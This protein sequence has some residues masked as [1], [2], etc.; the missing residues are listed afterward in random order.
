MRYISFCSGVE[1]ATLAWHGL[2]WRPVAFSEIEPFPCAVLA[3]RWP[4][5]PNLG[6]M[7]KLEVK[8]NG[9]IAS[10]VSGISTSEPIDLIVGGTPC[11]V[12]GT[13][14]LT[15]HGY[16]PIE[17][18]R[19]GDMVLTDKFRLRRVVRTGS[20]EADVVTVKIFGKPEIICTPNHPFLVA[21][22]H[23]SQNNDFLG[24]AH[25]KN[26]DDMKY[27]PIGE[28]KG[29][30]A[31]V[32]ER[33]DVFISKILSVGNVLET[34]TVFNIEVE[35]DHT[36]VAAG[37]FVH[38]CQSY[39]VA[40]KREGNRG[41]SGLSLHYTTMAYK[42]L[43]RWVLWENV[44]GC[45]SSTQGL[46]F[47]AFLSG[48]CGWDAPVPDGGW[49]NSGICTN[50]PGCF[51][52]AWRTLDCQ[53]TRVPGFP[54]AIPQRRR[55][56]F[57]VGYRGQPDGSPRDWERAAE[58]LFDG[59]GLFGNPP[60]RGEK[61]EGAPADSC[62]GSEGADSGSVGRD[63]RDGGCSAVRMREGCEGGGKGPLVSEGRSLAL[64]SSNDQVLFR[65]QTGRPWDESGV[66]PTLNQA[67][68]KSGGIGASD[69]EI[70][71]QKGNGLVLDMQGGKAG[72]KVSA[73]G[74]CPTILRGRG[75][76]NDIHCIVENTPPRSC[77]R[78]TAFGEYSMDESAST[79]KAR[80]CKD[81]TDLVVSNG[82][83]TPAT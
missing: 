42:S 60:P 3:S 12:A 55:R 44:P 53:Y 56:V 17:D 65:P 30:Y 58:V 51:G 78:M 40:G 77:A 73:D 11:F 45:L 71:S 15:E 48:L 66:N 74:S 36:Y 31:A 43:C 24:Y 35:E 81:A 57:L 1:A 29:R 13:M 38:N 20:K 9:T 52:V 7:T 27:L 54:R 32:L 26:F 10:A 79:V 23:A 33:S 19:E 72:A 21:S 22:A 46:D 41:V 76:A 68:G 83:R 75:D 67:C 49:K 34:R 64:A 59:E 28:C 80:D 61:G 47:K 63:G 50:A 25:G 39:S 5:V 6:D 70:F 18:I 2:G 62:E 8:E 69:Q 82:T 37:V 4:D 14:I 16:R